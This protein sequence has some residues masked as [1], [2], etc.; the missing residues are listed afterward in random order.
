MFNYKK[1]NWNKIHD[2]LSHL[3]DIVLQSFTSFV[4]KTSLFTAIDSAIPKKQ[5]KEK[6]YVHGMTNK[7]RKM[8]QK[9][10]RYSRSK[11]SDN[12]D[13]ESQFK[14]FRK[15]VRNKSHA[16]YHNYLN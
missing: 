13:A 16:S 11:K 7:I 8:I 10:H 15:K 2:E 5:L 6:I 12:P 14:D 3:R 1:T 4:F 9:K